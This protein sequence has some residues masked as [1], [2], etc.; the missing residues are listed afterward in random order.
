VDV[1]VLKKKQGRAYDSEE[2]LRSVLIRLDAAD[3]VLIRRENG[4]WGIERSAG[5]P[6]LCVSVS[7]TSGYWACAASEEGPLG[8]DIEERGRRVQPRTLRILH[9]AEQRYLAVLE[10][11]SAEY[12]QAFLEIWTRKESYVKYLGRGLA[13][14]MSSFSVVGETGVFLETLPNPDGRSVHVCSPDIGSG[15]QAA[16]CST[17]KSG[18]VSVHRFSDPGQPV[19]PP[20]EHAADFLSRRDYASGQLKKKLLEKGHSPEAAAQTVQQLA[21]DGYIDD[22]RFAEDYAK[23]AIEK[24]KGRRRIVRELMERGVEPGEAQQ[25]ALQADDEAGGSDYERALA[26]AQ[27]MLEKEGLAGEDPVPDK[28]KAR[29][30]RRLSS[31]GY[32]SQDIWRVLEHLRSEA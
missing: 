26:Q 24:G 28:L 21:Q 6:A 19:K 25:A 30:A 14:G 4:T 18:A 32:E 3:A 12:G 31:L 9:P 2:L 15:L 8:F 10:E 16:I 22:S 5:K 27:S 1:F 13:F 11:G 20:L 29:I 23:R 7:H 17:G